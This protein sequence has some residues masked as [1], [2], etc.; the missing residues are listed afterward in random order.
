MTLPWGV[1]YSGDVWLSDP[2]DLIDAQFTTAGARLSDF[3][4]PSNGDWGGDM[5]FDTAR[6][7]LWQVNVG[8]DNGIY[9]INPSDGSVVQVITVCVSA[10]MQRHAPW[11]AAFNAGQYVL[12]FGVAAVILGLGGRWPQ[13]TA[14]EDATP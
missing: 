5:A 2:I 9:G 13:L 3:P 8:G 10:L 14:T 11:R 4:K 6:N 12:A 1:G 7:L